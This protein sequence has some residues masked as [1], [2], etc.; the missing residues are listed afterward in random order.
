MT[1]CGAGNPRG[2]G[3]DLGEQGDPEWEKA[4]VRAEWPEGQQEHRADAGDQLHQPAGPA[5]GQE[6]TGNGWAAPC[7]IRSCLSSVACVWILCSQSA[8]ASWQGGRLLP[9]HAAHSACQPGGVILVFLR[10]R[11]FTCR[12][13]CGRHSKLGT[14][15]VCTSLWPCE[16]DVHVC[17]LCGGGKKQI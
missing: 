1:E 17:R 7:H 10:P 15:A 8:R 13:V 5:G 2:E 6:Q 11:S 16:V 4:W 12:S 3:E 9:Q 14:W